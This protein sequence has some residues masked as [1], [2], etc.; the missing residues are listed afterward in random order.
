MTIRHLEEL[1]NLESQIL[2]KLMSNAISDEVNVPELS[3]GDYDI[4]LD[5]ELNDLIS[6]LTII[7]VVKIETI[8]GLMWD[9]NHI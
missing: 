6:A 4:I 1:L 7:L 9:H 5:N 3:Y 2:R 8:G